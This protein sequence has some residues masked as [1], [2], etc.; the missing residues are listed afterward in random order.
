MADHIQDGA[1]PRWHQ[2]LAWALTGR[3]WPELGRQDAPDLD[4]LTRRLR[5]APG[6]AALRDPGDEAAA[7]GRSRPHP[8]PAELM[9]GLGYAQFA[10]ALTQLR[11]E[12][13]LDGTAG[14]VAP[15]QPPAPVS[16]E[17][18]RLLDEVPPHHG[19]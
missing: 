17:E 7:A 2:A 5:S 3:S 19:S 1:P 11:A 14:L 16:A 12:L 18:R 4:E 9:A 8:V 13:G 6:I 10:A 15:A